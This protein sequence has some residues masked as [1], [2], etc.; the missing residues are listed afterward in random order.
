MAVSD[1]PWAQFTEAMYSI[2]QWRRA[3][4]VDTGTGD[5]E[6]KA[7]YKLPV[8][9][10]DG[11]LNRNGVHAAAGGHGIG[12]VQGISS[13]QRRAAARTLV[14]LYRN[15]LGE[16]P[17]DSLL[18]LAGM[19]TNSAP[20]NYQT[21]EVMTGAERRY[22]SVPVELRATGHQTIGGYAAVF[23]RLSEN[24]G[25]FVEQVAPTSFNKSRGDDWPGVVARFDH[26]NAFLLGTS[27]ARTLRLSIDDTG[28]VYEVDPPKA[29]QDIVELVERGDVRR[30]SFAF[31]VPTGG[32]EWGLSDQ[33]Y[34][35]RTLV[36]VQL[37]DVAPVVSPA[38]ADTTA[39]LRSL[40]AAK[41]IEFDEVRTLAI[42]NELRKLFVRTDGGG[43][44]KPPTKR[45][46]GPSAVA[47]LLSKRDDPYA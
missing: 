1:K 20:D 16:E 40:A 31:R 25:G 8:R 28:L 30:S 35:L 12:A 39:G 37:V 32:D 29:R 26:E 45:T 27:A 9:E 36:S 15:Q 33:N 2:G 11:V 44:P 42:D 17:P 13:E 18:T 21:G 34:P 46:F 6:S 47:T 19:S 24:L 7:R 23:N 43:K 4:L 5:P 3:C 10:P 38:Y 14:G 41:G 22:T